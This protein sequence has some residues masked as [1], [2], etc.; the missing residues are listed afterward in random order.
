MLTK[1][2][3]QVVESAILF[4]LTTLFQRLQCQMSYSTLKRG[5]PGTPNMRSSIFCSTTF[6]MTDQSSL[7]ALSNATRLIQRCTIVILS[8]NGPWRDRNP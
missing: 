7:R 6:R 2:R 3:G 8:P 1:E 5:L 4:R